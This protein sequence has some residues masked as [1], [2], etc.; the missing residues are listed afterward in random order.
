MQFI[1]QKENMEMINKWTSLPNFLI[2]QGDQHMGKRY[3]TIWLAEKFNLSYRELNKSVGSIRDTIAKLRSNDNILYHLDNFE[4]ASLA[5]KNALLKVTEEP[6]KGNY[7]VIT[8]GPQI[9][10]LES[11]ARRIIMS[12]Y[13]REELS[14]FLDKYYPDKQLQ[15]RL[16]IAGINSPAKI[17]YYKDYEAL[18]PLVN[19]A[20][21]IFTKITYITPESILKLL[22]RF[23]NRYDNKI[24]ATMLFLTML[25]NIIEYNIKEKGYHSYMNILKILLKGKKELSVQPTLK[26][27]MLLFDIFYNIYKSREM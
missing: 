23:E 7:F 10:T 22:P 19:Y 9:K 2:I 15:N 21:D 20:H 24:D 1:G 14:I 13:T 3:L 16:I 5:A 25:I 18:E 27:K 11:R 26:R 8:G 6:I 12:P 17:L 4:S